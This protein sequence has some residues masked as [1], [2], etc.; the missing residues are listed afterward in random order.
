MPT[1]GVPNP[2]TTVAI[3]DAGGQ[4]YNVKASRFGAVGDGTTDDTAAVQAAI[5][6]AI[7]SGGTVYFPSATYRIN[8]QLTFTNDAGSPPQQKAL[9]ITGDTPSHNGASPGSSAPNGGSILDL[10]YSGA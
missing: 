9:R 2:L 6:A 10:R 3:R 7:V 5:N 1:F 4:V 8:S